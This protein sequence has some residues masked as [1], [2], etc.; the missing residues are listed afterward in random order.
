MRQIPG[1]PMYSITPCGQVWSHY[2]NR[3]IKLTVR[4]G[5]G[6]RRVGLIIGSPKK[7]KYYYVHQ[8]VMLTYI[9]PPP[10]G[11]EIDHIDLDTGNNNLDNLRYVS[12]RENLKTRRH[13]NQ[14]IAKRYGYV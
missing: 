2:I 6:Y 13:S 9:G 5:S 11:C 7:Y 8:L 4:K 1:H 10:V 3:F 12:H 14:Y